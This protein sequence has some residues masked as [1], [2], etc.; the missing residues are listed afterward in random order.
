MTE[1]RRPHGDTPV[2][3]HDVCAAL[4]RYGRAVAH[5]VSLTGR[6]VEAGALVPTRAAADARLDESLRRLVE[7]PRR[8]GRPI[9]RASLGYANSVAS[10]AGR[11]ES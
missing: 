10:D 8:S 2:V 6:P 7:A 9:H 5:E 1:A 3:G 11:G 4:R